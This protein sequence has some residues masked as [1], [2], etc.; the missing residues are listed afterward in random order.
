MGAEIPALAVVA[1]A[2]LCSFL[3]EHSS[4]CSS[5]KA[6]P[7]LSRASAGAF[8]CFCQAAQ[9]SCSDIKMLDLAA[10][11]ESYGLSR[12]L[13]CSIRKLETV[14]RQSST[15][16]T[17]VV[18]PLDYENV[19]LQ[20]RVQIYSDPL[21]DLLIFPIEDVSISVI[22]RQRRTVQSTVPEDALKKAQSLFVKECIKTYSSDW[23]VVNY[24]YE[25]YSGD[26]RML[27]W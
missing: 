21:R 23:F 25:E 12:R 3:G 10:V 24:K 27:P 18:E 20:R 19:I 5:S 8:L 4:H 13:S 16:K 6:S 7:E 17:K 22:G 26:F 11:K 2:L 14:L 15:E 1:A 9:M